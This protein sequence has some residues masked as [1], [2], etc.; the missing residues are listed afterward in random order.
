MRSLLVLLIFLAVSTFQADAHPNQSTVTASVQTTPKSQL[1]QQYVKAYNGG[2]ATMAAFMRTSSV[3]DAP[4]SQRLER[5]R[6]M[7]SDLGDLTLL[8]M[9]A[10]S[11]DGVDVLVQAASGT[12][13]QMTFLMNGDES[14]KV[15]GVRILPA[16]ENG[17]PPGRVTVRPTS[18]NPENES[19]VLDR[20]RQLAQDRSKADT[21]SGAIL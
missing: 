3:S 12:K 16:G 8:S 13:L 19:V 6:S 11:S 2:E 1:V 10:E 21:F 9:I 18:S 4:F 5:Y 17:P 20:I 7:R 15:T 14:P